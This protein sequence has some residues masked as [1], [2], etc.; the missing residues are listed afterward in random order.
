MQTSRRVS[1]R[2]IDDDAFDTHHRA[3]L[4]P[5][6]MAGREAALDRQRSVRFDQPLDLPHVGD[7]L[8]GVID[9]EHPRN[10]VGRQPANALR[11]VGQHED[12]AGEEAA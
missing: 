10:A 11:L 9:R 6:P 2:R 3:L 12:V 7:Q 8:L 4:D 1:P 5:H